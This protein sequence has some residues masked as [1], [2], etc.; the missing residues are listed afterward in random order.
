MVYPN[1]GMVYPMKHSLDLTLGHL[2]VGHF[3]CVVGCHRRL[4]RLLSMVRAEGFDEIRWA[5]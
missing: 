1:S 4:P 2:P 5:G 3:R